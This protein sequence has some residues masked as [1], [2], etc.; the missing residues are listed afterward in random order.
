M[1][2]TLL[3]KNTGLWGL[4]N[5]AG[6]DT[7]VNIRFCSCRL[8]STEGTKHHIYAPLRLLLSKQRSVASTLLSGHYIA[9]QCK[10][11]TQSALS[12]QKQL[13]RS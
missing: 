10:I 7:A 9:I 6:H 8:V 3:A 11:L 1:E 12:S 4:V 5:R 13:L 2:K